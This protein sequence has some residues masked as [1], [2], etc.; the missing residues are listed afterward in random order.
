MMKCSALILKLPYF[1]STDADAK[2]IKA[3]FI[4]KSKE[5]HPDTNLDDPE[6]S[7]KRFQEIVAAYEILNDEDKKSQ[8]DAALR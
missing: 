2:T 7:A 5:S 8:L 4:T 3:A 1:L 6:G